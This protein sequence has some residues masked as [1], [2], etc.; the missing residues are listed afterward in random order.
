MTA[1]TISYLKNTSFA[2]GQSGGITAEDMRDF[3][4]SAAMEYGGIYFTTP[5]ATT[6]SVA[7]TYYKASGTTTSTNLSTNMDMPA[8]NRLRYTGTVMRHFHIVGQASITL[9]SGTNQDIGIQVYKY[10]DSAGS[11]ALLAHSE[12]RTTIPGTNVV[13]IT[14]HADAMLD[15]NDYLELHIAN[16][17]GTNNCTVEFGYVFGVGM[18]T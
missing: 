2:D 5:A 11:G 14:T 18:I 4:D 13:Q 15:E 9:A 8:D 12:A 1:R 7:T 10:D 3:V 17:T 6:I 16:H